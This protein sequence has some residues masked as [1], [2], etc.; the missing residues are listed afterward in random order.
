MFWSIFPH[1]SYRERRY[2]NKKL[3]HEIRTYGIYLLSVSLSLNNLDKHIVHGEGIGT[4][5][6]PLVLTAKGIDLQTTDKKKMLLRDCASLLKEPTQVAQI[7]KELSEQKNSVQSIPRV[8]E[9]LKCWTL[10]TSTLGFLS[11]AIIGHSPVYQT[12]VEKNIQFDKRLLVTKGLHL[13]NIKAERNS[14]KQ[15]E[16]L[17][18]FMCRLA[19]FE[20][21]DM[22]SKEVFR[23]SAENNLYVQRINNYLLIR[24]RAS[25]HKNVLSDQLTHR[26]YE[27]ISTYPPIEAVSE[28]STHKC[29]IEC[30]R[31]K[32]GS[33]YQLLQIRST[34][35]LDYPASYLLLGLRYPKEYGK[36]E[37]QDLI[38]RTVSVSFEA[39][40]FT[41]SLLE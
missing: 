23:F 1:N 8:S 29:I 36:Y 40:P 39:H 14:I 7:Y 31:A 13:P 21:F 4:T 6:L 33:G 34:C 18:D 26:V 30:K 28:S 2:R 41:R 12:T 11:N 20:P 19:C 15:L 16:T 22:S 25:R 17:R 37:F 27:L 9:P 32:D 24:Q 3:K 10:L 38:R 5:D 35:A